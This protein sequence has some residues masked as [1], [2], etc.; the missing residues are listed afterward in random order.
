MISVVLPAAGQGTRMNCDKNKQFLTLND[1]P[2]LA[3]T[4]NAFQ[5]NTRVNEIIIVARTGE[6]DFCR[7]KIV[8]KYKFDKVK[9]IIEGGSTRQQS[10][11]NG[12]Q[13]VAEG[14]EFVLVHD[15]ARPLVEEDLIEKVIDSVK[16]TKAVITAVPV[17]DTIKLV[18]KEDQVVETLD[19]SRLRAV[20]TPQAFAT[21]LLSRAYRQALEQ[22]ITGTDSSSLV[23][24]LTDKQVAVVEGSY[25]NLKVTTPDDLK[26]AEN[27]IMRR[28]QCE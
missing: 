1:R 26:I 13:A 27:I 17:K 11:N 9:K 21:G 2:L 3:H 4:I 15:G 5:E 18:T 22:G 8:D 16:Q 25:E 19:R 20:Q 6:I 28:N 12:L 10:V 7:R 24:K 14:S 23:E